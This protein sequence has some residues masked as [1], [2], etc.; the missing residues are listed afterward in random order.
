MF[1]FAFSVSANSLISALQQYGFVDFVIPF[2]LI[3][4]VVYA[5]LQ[6]AKLFGSGEDAKK[7][8]LVIALAIGL[9]IT[10]PHVLSPQPNDAVSIMQRFLPE[11]VYIALAILVVLMLLGMFTEEPGKKGLIS[12]IAGLLAVAYLVVMIV[13]AIGD[14]NIPLAIFQDPNL[15]AV[16]IIILVFALVIYYVTGK[17]GEGIGFDK[18]EKWVKAL[19]GRD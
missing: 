15:V 11:F 19:L 5:L 2:I 17:E 14:Y 12:G 1:Q 16:I 8:N 13:S 18:A 6:Q 9:I 4:A 10:I 7:Y 3:F